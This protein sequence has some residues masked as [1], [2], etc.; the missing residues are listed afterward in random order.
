M[1]PIT[2]ALLI[3][4][5]RGRVQ[6]EPRR[7]EKAHEHHNYIIERQQAGQV[8]GVPTCGGSSASAKSTFTATAQCSRRTTSS[9]TT[10]ADRIER[11]NACGNHAIATILRSVFAAV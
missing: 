10:S 6:A 11:F 4:A 2:I 9:V 1:K 8:Q 7:H 3:L 5:T